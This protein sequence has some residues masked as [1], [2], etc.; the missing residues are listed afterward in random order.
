MNIGLL[1]A[2]QGLLGFVLISITLGYLALLALSNLS[3]TILVHDPT[4]LSKY[5]AS[6]IVIYAGYAAL[7]LVSR[8]WTR[9][10]LVV[11]DIIA[12]VA[13]L[14]LLP[15]II[16]SV[17][18]AVS[19][20]TKIPWSG[21]N[22]HKDETILWFIS[23]SFTSLIAYAWVAGRAEGLVTAGGEGSTR[24]RRSVG[25][26]AEQLYSLSVLKDVPKERQTV[27]SRLII[28]ALQLE[29]RSAVILTGIVF[30]LICAALFIVFAGQIT[31]LD[32]SGTKLVSLAQSDVRAAEDELQ[33]VNSAIGDRARKLAA[34]KE[35]AAKSQTDT[36]SLPTDS[37][38]DDT[39]DD[40][41]KTKLEAKKLALTAANANLINVRAR[42]YQDDRT[43]DQTS[44]EILLIQTSVT[45]FGVVL[46]MVF[47]VQ[48]LVNLY[49]Y[50]MRLSAF[51]F[52]R[53][54]A[55]I[56]LN[57]GEDELNLA[58]LVELISPDKFDF[59]K[60]PRTPAQEAGS[61]IQAWTGR[62]RGP[63][64]SDE[65]SKPK[66]VRKTIG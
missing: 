58:T 41:L 13:R 9:G 46:I 27:I 35:Q 33:A 30:M 61:L 17:I 60:S 37:T 7:L 51:Y 47:L 11:S 28:R 62:L 59:G 55:L 31:S 26:A 16:L 56:L 36:K 39:N 42:Q 44:G 53:A 40:F 21:E 65:H 22:A 25:V 10:S 64:D 54:D 38:F 63:E 45:R 6:L 34:A 29:R 8:A 24:H 50:N 52:G 43:K 5:V 66:K 15:G 14:G 48:I 18:L 49:R 57:K 23:W 3:D 4:D 19:L 32:V 20:E 2:R 12:D 1:K